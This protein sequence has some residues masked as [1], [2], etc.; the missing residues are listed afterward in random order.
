MGTM[1]AIFMEDRDCAATRKNVSLSEP[2]RT[3]IGT[4]ISIW[5]RAAMRLAVRFGE[6]RA[7][8]VDRMRRGVVG[9]PA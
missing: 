1:L 7:R 9:W 5:G 6:I 2:T 3:L 8:G 4:D